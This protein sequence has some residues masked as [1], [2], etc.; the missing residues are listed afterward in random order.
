MPSRALVSLLIAMLLLTGC[1]LFGNSKARNEGEAQALADIAAGKPAI[2]VWDHPPSYYTAVD[3]ETG[4]PT[5]D[6]SL[7]CGTGVDFDAYEARIEG[8]NATIR[9]A[10]ARGELDSFR[11][12]DKVL[13]RA[14]AERLFAAGD[15][16][17]LIEGQATS[18][19]PEGGPYAVELRAVRTPRA[20]EPVIV[21]TQTG[22][23][24]SFRFYEAS[25]EPCALTF[26]HHGTT[27]I[28][29][30]SDGTLLTWDLPSGRHLQSLAAED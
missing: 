10:L 5:D 29:R 4:L 28:V 25:S 18:C 16:F 17:E 9:A 1:G 22:E 19:R 26:A 11:F 14:E 20:S 24:R 2:R 13:T 27:L 6:W 3:A 15:P 23:A 12:T 30:R 7:H 8:Y 21:D